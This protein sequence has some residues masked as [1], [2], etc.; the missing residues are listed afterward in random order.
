MRRYLTVFLL[1]LTAVLFLAPFVSAEGTEV[2]PAY[3]QEL[4]GILLNGEE[5]YP[6]RDYTGDWRVSEEGIRVIRQE[7]SSSAL[8][9]L[10]VRSS[11]RDNGITLTYDGLCRPER[12]NI[13]IIPMCVDD[14]ADEVVSR[15]RVRVELNVPGCTVSSESVVEANRWCAYGMDVTGLD[16]IK[17]ITLTLE[18]PDG[19][20]PNTVRLSPI[21]FTEGDAFVNI[22]KYLCPDFEVSGGRLVTRGDALFLQ[23]SGSTAEIEGVPSFVD[24]P[25]D[26]TR[27]FFLV[28]LSGEI[29]DGTL[30]FSIQNGDAP[31]REFAPVKLRRGEYVYSFPFSAGEADRIRLTFRNAAAVRGGIGIDAISVLWTGDDAEAF[32]GKGYITSVDVNRIRDED[33]LVVSGGVSHAA[34]TEHAKDELVLYAV[35]YGEVHR[36][37]EGDPADWGGIELTR[38][39]IYMNFELILD[40]TLTRKYIGTHMFYVTIE[41]GEHGRILLAEPRGVEVRQPKGEEMS[42]VGLSGASAVGVFESNASHVIV[43]IPFDR[44]VYG[45]VG[46]GRGQEEEPSLRDAVTITAGDGTAIRLNGTFLRELSADVSFFASADMKVYLRMTDG[47]RSFIDRVSSMEV[48]E[49]EVYSAV[50]A[51]LLTMDGGVVGNAAAGVI[52]GNDEHYDAEEFASRSMY[53]FSRKLTEL[54]RVTYSTAV[55]AV[56]QEKAASIAVILPMKSGCTYGSTVIQ[57]VSIHLKS[58]GSVPWVLMPAFSAEDKSGD[59]RFG[60]AL[61]EGAMLLETARNYGSDGVLARLMYFYTPSSEGSGAGVTVEYNNLCGDAEKYDP[62]VIFLSVEGSSDERTEQLYRW[63]KTVRKEEKNSIIETLTPEILTGEAEDAPAVGTVYTPWDFSERYYSDG[64]IAGGTVS[65]CTT[66]RSEIFSVEEGSSV[67]VLRTPVSS[68][69]EHSAASAIVLRNFN[70]VTDLSRV[71][72]IIFRFAISE[73]Y[74]TATVIFIVG[75]DRIRAEYTLNDVAAGQIHTVRCPVSDFS[76]SKEAAYI[77]VMVYASDAAVLEM[78]SVGLWSDTLAAEE[79]A[80]LFAAEEGEAKERSNM[81]IAVASVIGVISV[82]LGAAMFRRD[83]EEAEMYGDTQPLVGRDAVLSY[84]NTEEKR[85]RKG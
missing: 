27:A 42:V 13:L 61:S 26:G 4:D 60:E 47:A 16:R 19:S 12:R 28:T 1:T 78:S 41:G 40:G 50:L 57:M 63:L 53:Y 48:R 75:N 18:C 25:S 46:T 29:T 59:G 14:G 72:D 79:L 35:P 37:G 81:W 33:R 74:D 80:A 68:D 73:T 5:I 38:S 82:I 3:V 39:R 51:H 24:I 43:D 83:R 54:M 58:L 84:G 77:G 20:V 69:S 55:L 67:R 45:T 11:F 9:R 34:M 10:S 8:L 7:E 56:G 76:G 44:L 32:A 6:D 49:S 2:R 66:E 52:L 31:Y 36:V 15:Y 62:M 30:T 22:A 17:G 85:G 65:G 64:W 71:D 70:R 21:Y 23:T